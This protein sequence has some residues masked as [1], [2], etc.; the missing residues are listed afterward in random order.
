[1]NTIIE[2]KIRQC[3]EG[4][5]L[6]FAQ[7]DTILTRAGEAPTGVKFLEKGTVEQYH[8]TPAGNK[9]IVNVFKPP[10]FF[11]MSWAMNDT[12]NAYF[13]A[14]LTDIA[15]RQISKEDAVAFLQ[16]NPDVTFNLLARVYR[17]TDGLL[18]RLV[19]AA[20]S[21]AT[22]RLIYELI[23]EAHRFGVETNDNRIAIKLKQSTLAARSGLA[24]ETISR[25]LRRL[26]EQ[27][28]V[29]QENGKLLLRIEELEEKL[30]IAI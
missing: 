20:S 14:A 1:M 5:P 2:T 27:G 17:G 21:V 30:D 22:G 8:I 28:A 16:S 23:L 12:T 25:E 15:F 3:F 26:I 7:K 6:Q 10:A 4:S 11:P 13:Y 18:R 19:L 24:R 29:A 9:V